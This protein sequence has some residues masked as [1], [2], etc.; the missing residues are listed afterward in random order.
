MRR[1]IPVAPGVIGDDGN[2]LAEQFDKFGG[3]EVAGFKHISPA[4]A[5]KLFGGIAFRPAAGSFIDR[6]T[7]P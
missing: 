1:A 6:M 4:A 5:R 3:H 2:A 7:I